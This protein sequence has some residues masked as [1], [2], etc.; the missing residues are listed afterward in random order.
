M[1]HTGLL[2]DHA[3]VVS[4][5]VDEEAPIEVCVSRLPALPDVAS[6]SGRARHRIVL[7]HGNPANM[8]DFG[9]LAACLRSE[10]EVLALDLPGFGRSQAVP[11]ATRGSIL[12]SYARHVRA[13]LVS[14]GWTH[15]YHVVGHSH[16]AAVAQ[17]LALLYP[18]EVS[19][20]VLLAAVGTPAHWAIASSRLR[21]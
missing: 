15:G 20:L 11:R 10:F 8:H 12:H 5:R 18:E 14:V 19:G 3:E 1:R 17:T 6:G 13:A 7:L 9:P 2:Y 4:A 16:G 21:A